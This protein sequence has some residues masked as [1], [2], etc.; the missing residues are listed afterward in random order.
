VCVKCGADCHALVHRL[1]G[2]EKGARGWEER[3][4]SIV[5]RLAPRWVPGPGTVVSRRKVMQQP[6]AELRRQLHA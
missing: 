5:A 4:R 2:V 6:C 1:Q 3:R